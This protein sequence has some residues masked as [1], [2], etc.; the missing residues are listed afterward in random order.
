MM[1]LCVR[2]A[3]EVKANISLGIC[4]EHGGNPESIAFCHSIGLHYVA[5]RPLEY[6]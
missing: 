2:K 5:V 4:G 3:R 6:Q 1:R